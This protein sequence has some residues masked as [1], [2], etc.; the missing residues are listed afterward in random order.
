VKGGYFVMI[1][2][3][4]Q[5]WQSKQ[6]TK[7]PFISV[8][9]ALTKNPK[10]KQ[11]KAWVIEQTQ[12]FPPDTAMKVRLQYLLF[13]YPKCQYC[14]KP[15]KRLNAKHTDFQKFC[16]ET[17]LQKAKREKI[18]QTMIERYGVP[19]LLQ[20][21]QFKKQFSEN[22]KAKFGVEWFSK[23]DEWYEKTKQ[24]MIERYGDWNLNAQRQQI[25]QTWLAKYGVDNPLKSPIVKQ[26]QRQTMIERY[27]EITNLLLPENQQKALTK[28]LSNLYKNSHLWN[29]KTTWAQFFDENG[30]FDVEKC[31]EFFGITHLPIIRKK[32]KEFGW[33]NVLMS[34][35]NHFLQT[36]FVMKIREFYDG[37]IQVD[38]HDLIDDFE[39]DIYIPEHKLA[40][41]VDGLMYHSIGKSKYE[42]FNNVN[43]LA[44]ERK[45]AKL[46]QAKCEAKGIQLLRVFENEIY[47]ENKLNIWLN[48]IKVKLGLAS[49]VIPARKCKLVQIPVEIERQFL[50]KNHLQGYIS[51]KIAFGLLYE[52]ELV[53]VMS[54]SDI[55]FKRKGLANKKGYELLRYAIKDDY[56]VVGG[57]GKLLKHFERLMKPEYIISYANRRWSKGDLYEKLGFKFIGVTKSNYWYF[58]PSGKPKNRSLKN[59]IYFQ[60]HKLKNLLPNFDKNLSEMANMFNNGYRVIFDNGNKVYLKYC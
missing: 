19:Y 51:S 17:C 45:R 55:R 14:N 60:K 40:I 58:N 37:E 2:Q 53:A 3:L 15:V 33:V 21:E 50:N 12:Q 16:S 13:G 27:G 11:L 20:D 8:S 6:N 29:D 56:V 9:V 44:F 59:R 28:R 22:L 31:V 43:N 57:A 24:T 18:E 38:V 23:S 1:N 35:S 48:M 32:L 7:K 41:E 42:K 26:K 47:D 36:E 52:N 10:Y 34:N 5:L 25:E 4:K 54:F 39:I 49:K 30:I 46:K